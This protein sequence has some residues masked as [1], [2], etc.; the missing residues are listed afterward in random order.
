MIESVLPRLVKVIFCKH[1]QYA[2]APGKSGYLLDLHA[3]HS[4]SR[5]TLAAKD[6]KD[7]LLYR[8]QRN[9]DLHGIR[10]G[11]VDFAGELGLQLL[12]DQTIGVISLQSGIADA[13]EPIDPQ[14]GTQVIIHVQE[15]DPDGPVAEVRKLAGGLHSHWLES[16]GFNSRLLKGLDLTIFG[17]VSLALAPFGVTREDLPGLVWRTPADGIR[18]IRRRLLVNNPDLVCEINQA[19]YPGRLRQMSPAQLGQLRLKLGQR[20]T[21]ENVRAWK[22]DGYRHVP[23]W[24]W[25]PP[26]GLGEIC[27]PFMSGENLDK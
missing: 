20:L 4:A 3:R 24:R 19:E 5:F 21:R 16:A 13:N 11:A 9:D 18:N 6:G 25:L 14:A 8:P 10:R 26:G 12:K 15:R 23:Q 7:V 17:A 27:F 22:I 1:P 2:A